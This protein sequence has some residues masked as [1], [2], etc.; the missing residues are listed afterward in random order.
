MLSDDDDDDTES[1]KHSRRIVLRFSDQFHRRP[2]SE[3]CHCH[4][5]VATSLPSLHLL[6]RPN[7]TTAILFLPGCRIT[8][9]STDSQLCR[10]CCC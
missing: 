10:S 1:S 8:W 5:H 6:F 2:Y 7:L 3:C 4:I 9:L